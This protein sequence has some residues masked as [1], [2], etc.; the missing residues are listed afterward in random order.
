MGV[1][2]LLTVIAGSAT[3]IGGL[4]GVWGPHTSS[5]LLSA[6]VALSAG[7]MIYISL[8]E[9]MP[10]ALASVAKP[11]WVIVGFFS[12]A[13]FVLLVEFL[14]GWYSPANRQRQ[15]QSVTLHASQAPTPKVDHPRDPARLTR[16][17]I[18]MAVVLAAHNAPEGF[19]TLIYALQDPVLALP[20]V[21]AIAV[22]NIPEGIAVA[23]PMYHST[24]NRLKAWGI[25]AASG[26]AEPVGAL[27]LYAIVGPFL[28][29]SAFGVVNGVIA[30]IMVFISVHEL[31]PLALATGKKTSVSLWVLLGMALMA[32]SL[33][34]LA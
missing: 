32:G 17:A 22:H 8:V 33:L 30:G 26:M 27:V 1:A 23:V 16:T 31:I 10:A 9:L 20:L 25:S 12:G 6:G 21:F 2:I 29:A 19:V 5:R 28:D 7:V 34:V 11:W 18:I 13:M 15:V 24:G 14:A 4:I 3:A